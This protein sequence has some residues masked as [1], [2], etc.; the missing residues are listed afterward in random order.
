LLG[1]I[2]FLAWW[3]SSLSAENAKNLHTLIKNTIGKGLALP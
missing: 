3:T 1:T 2:T